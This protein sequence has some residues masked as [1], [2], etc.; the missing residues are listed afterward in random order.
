MTLLTVSFGHVEQAVLDDA[1]VYFTLS[2]LSYPFLAV[3]N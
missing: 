1:M 2:A 3:Y